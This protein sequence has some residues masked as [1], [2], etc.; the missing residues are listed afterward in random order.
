MTK[1]DWQNWYSIFYIHERGGFERYFKCFMWRSS[2]LTKINRR[3]EGAKGSERD[4]ISAKS[5]ISCGYLV[6]TT[7]PY[8]L[9]DVITL[10]SRECNKKNYPYVFIMLMCWFWAFFT[11]FSGVSSSAYQCHTQ[12]QFCRWLMNQPVRNWSTWIFFSYGIK[13]KFFH[14]T[15]Y[16]S[17]VFQPLFFSD[18][19]TRFFSQKWNR[20]WKINLWI[21]RSVSIWSNDASSDYEFLNYR[22]HCF[23]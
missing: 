4:I 7:K 14:P 6:N 18:W 10:I 15:L 19:V 5:L 1:M 8:L 9:A 17:F 16:V 23:I 2:H 3:T 20:L 12:T 21:F 11:F 13:C 22:I